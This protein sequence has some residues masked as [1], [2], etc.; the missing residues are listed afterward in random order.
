M[1]NE[2]KVVWKGEK[3][4]MGKVRD[5]V[6]QAQDWPSIHSGMRMRRSQMLKQTAYNYN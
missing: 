2:G 6:K 1:G 5:W 4:H 3:M